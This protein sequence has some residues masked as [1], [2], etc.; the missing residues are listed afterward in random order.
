MFLIATS[1]INIKNKVNTKLQNNLPF[2]F[3]CKTNSDVRRATFRTEARLKGNK[4]ERNGR[5]RQERKANTKELKQTI[6]KQSSHENFYKKHS[7][8]I[9]PYFSLSSNLGVKALVLRMKKKDTFF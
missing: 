6:K 1:Y 9:L 2:F 5:N 3:K 4:T 8:I 7:Y